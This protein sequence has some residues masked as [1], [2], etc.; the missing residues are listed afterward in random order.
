VPV[1]RIMGYKDV[2]VFFLW[3]KQGFTVGADGNPPAGFV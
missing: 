3:L 2:E 1:G